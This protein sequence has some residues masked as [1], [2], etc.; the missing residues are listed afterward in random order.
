VSAFK[1]ATP[2]IS[3]A[4]PYTTDFLGWF[5]DFST[6]GGG[7]DAIGAYA[8]ASISLAENN[9]LYIMTGPPKTKQFKRCP[10]SAEGPAPD[11]S[12]VFS[13]EERARLDCQEQDRAVLQN[14]T[15]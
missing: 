14:G 12:N 2:I 4:R 8:R 7:F 5:D 1:D 11:G 9:P 3:E 13:A 15:N 10:G 6:T